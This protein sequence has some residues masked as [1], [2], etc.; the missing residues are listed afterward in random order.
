MKEKYLTLEQNTCAARIFLNTFGLTL[1]SVSDVNEFSKIKILDKAMN[2][3]GELH[4]DNGKVII[5]AN[6]NNSVLDANFDVAKMFSFVD[7]EN[8][9]AFFGQWS[10]KI[11]FQVQKQDTVKLSGEFLIGSSADSEFGVSCL[12]QPLINCDVASKGTITLKIQRDGR[13]FGL[14]V[15]SGSYNETIDIIPWDNISGFIKHVISSGEY[16][17]ERYKHEYKKYTGVFPAGERDEDRLHV[18]LSETQWDNQISFRN[19]FP[20]KAGDDES[21]ALVIQKG[22][23]MQELDPDMFEKIK[24]LREVLSIGDVSLLDNLVSVCYE[25]YTDEELSV[26]LGLNRQR[27][28]YQN[29]AD[30][31]VKSYY[32]IG[33][34]NCFFPLEAQK[35]LLKKFNTNNLT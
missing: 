35:S 34:S 24:N 23:L 18:F 17:P 20:L 28:N 15:T 29:G 27:M 26:L 14:K 30:S 5:A 9:N 7:I 1:G 16:D 19:E 2:E 8:G 32:E 10:S 21:E 12:C 25:G 33:I 22:M 31:L 11:A 6:Y 3:V 13:A 4:F